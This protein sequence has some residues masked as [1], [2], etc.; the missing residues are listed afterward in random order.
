MNRAPIVVKS[1]DRVPWGKQEANIGAVQPGEEK[2]NCS[3]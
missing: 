2:F 1:M 3:M